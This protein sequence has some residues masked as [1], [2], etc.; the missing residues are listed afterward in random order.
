MTLRD[1]T[2]PVEDGMATYPGDP[3]VSVAEHASMASDGYR[4]TALELGT[5]TGTHVDAPSHVEPDGATLG[6]FG[7]GAFEFDAH[8]VDATGLDPREAIGPEAVPGT[9]ADLVLFHTGWE[10]RWGTDRYRAHPYLSRAA[11]ERC[12]G[13][14][15]AV[16]LDCFSP[17]P[18]PGSDGGNGFEGYGV[19][20]HRALL[21][22]GLL[23]VENL[24]GLGDLPER[25][26]VS[27]YPLRVD[28]DGAPARVVA[29]FEG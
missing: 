16:G 24:I 15:F 19:P 29:E 13:R 20:A 11:A 10:D 25:C 2:R 14:G 27:A 4:V 9:D 17:D 3:A 8:V 28:A 18:T 21:G 22:A 23:V 5:H 26:S 7:P 1:L 12:A 6:E